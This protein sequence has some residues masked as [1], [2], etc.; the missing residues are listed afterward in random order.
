MKEMKIKAKSLG[1]IFKK[2]AIRYRR[3]IVITLIIWTF[4]FFGLGTLSG[5]LLSKSGLEKFPEINPND[6]I[7]ILAPHIDDE[8]ISSGG[9]I[10]EAL[11]VKAQVNVVYL[12][13]GDDN[14][15]SV[16]KND[17]NLKVNPNDFITLGEKRM[18]E[19]KK[20]AGLLGLSATNLIFLGYPDRG[21]YSLLYQNYDSNKP[22]VSQGTELTYNPYSNT[23]R[24]Q[25]NYTGSNVFDDLTAIIKNFQPTIFIIPHHRDKNT[26][27]LATYLFQQKVFIEQTNKPKIF[28]YLV[29]YSFYPQQKKLN[30]NE[31]LYPPKK[32]FSDKSWYSF[33]LTSN[34]EKQK[35][36]AIKQFVSQKELGQFYDLLSSFVKKNEIFEVLE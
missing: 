33:N 21:L 26:D 10:Q 18:E 14:L 24:N 34:Q 30:Q 11:R 3:L 19:G 2:L 36:E 27:H 35:L 23:Y 25:Q 15:F 4:W 1:Q 16:I 32:L 22:Y 7:L 13:N 6:R 31:F 5:W 12:T 29:H 9:L 8:I 28:A 20:A 17:K